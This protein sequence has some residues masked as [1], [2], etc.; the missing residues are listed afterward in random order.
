MATKVDFR[1]VFDSNFF[2]ETLK[3]DFDLQQ[4]LAY[5]TSKASGNKKRQNII[6]A[7]SREYICRVN[8]L[9]EATVK[10]FFNKIEEP[11]VIESVEDEIIRTIKYAVHLTSEWPFKVV[12]FTSGDKMGIYENSE[13]YKNIKSISFK[14]NEDAREFIDYWFKKCRDE[15]LSSCE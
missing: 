11:E 12:I 9:N 4:K 14:S 5:I 3:G 7:K 2:E 13:H 8:N 6:S 15:R 10:I 1:F